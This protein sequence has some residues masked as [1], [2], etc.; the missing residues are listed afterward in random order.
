MGQIGEEEVQTEEL[1]HEKTDAALSHD[2][3]RFEA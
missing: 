1:L 3:L 2:D